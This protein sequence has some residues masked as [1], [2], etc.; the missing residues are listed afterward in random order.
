MTFP[1]PPNG[2]AKPRPP[3]VTAVGMTMFGLAGYSVIQQVVTLA[4][5]ISDIT[6]TRIL[7]S[8]LVVAF[9]GLIA[10]LAVFNL[11]GVNSA[12]IATWALFGLAVVSSLCFTGREVVGLMR[13]E[14][15]T[16]LG[17]VFLVLNLIEFAA[18]VAVVVLLALPA[19]HEFF[20]QPPAGGPQPIGFGGP[21]GNYPGHSPQPGQPP[22]PGQPQPQ[23]SQGQPPHYPG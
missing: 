16:G 3:V 17:A 10:M 20:R 21:A 13:G 14:P 22:H 1:P 23:P 9:A 19:S 8:V 12:R 15:L 11:R 4:I 5:S 7:S 18:I 6:V 2:S